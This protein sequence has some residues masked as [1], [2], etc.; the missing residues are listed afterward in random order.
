MG[1]FSI[2][3]KGKNEGDHMALAE[4]SF[5]KGDYVT[6]IDNYQK[7]IN[8]IF[9]GKEAKYY[10]HLTKKII[11]CNK[12]LGNYELV[13]ELWS[14]QY[15]PGDYGAKET[16]E[17]I[18]ILEA[19]QKYE[20]VMGVYNK[21]GKSLLRNKVEF[22]IRQ[23]KIPEAYNAM[24]ELVASV[25]ENHPEMEKLWLTKAKLSM[26]LLKFEEASR[27]LGKI[28]ERNP[29]NDEARKLK[30]FCIRNAKD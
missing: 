15:S 28:I 13:A 21:A 11:E 8:T 29:R 2:F 7:V 19:A 25:P 24:T 9:A 23:K 20:L 6:A 18:K 14:S 22:L 17:L 27:Y 26:S 16:Y 10:G 4:S 5:A 1:I 12:Q 30:D 3:K